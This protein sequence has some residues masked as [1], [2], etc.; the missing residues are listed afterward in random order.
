MADADRHYMCL[1]FISTTCLLT[2]VSAAEVGAPKVQVITKDALG[3]EARYDKSGTLIIL[4]QTPTTLRLFGTNFT[5]ST[6]IAFTAKNASLGTECSNLGITEEIVS[7]TEYDSTSTARFTVKLRELAKGQKYFYLC[8]KDSSGTDDW[9]HQGD[10]PWVRI[11]TERPLEE[12]T[13][14]PLWLQII[15]IG[16]LLC[17]SG[18]FSG[19]N[20]GLMS[21]DKTELKII[22][23][24]GSSS[25]KKYAK[26]ISPVRQRGNFLLCTLLLG[27]VLVNNTLTILLDDLTNGL[28]AIIGSTMAI[29][30]FGEIVPQAICSRHGL[31]VGAKT[32]WITRLFMV[33]TFVLS[34]PISL[35][36]DKILGEEIGQVYNREKLQELIRV[37]RDLND[38]EN[39]EMNIISG[40]LELSKKTVKDVMTKIEDVFMME[41]DAMLDFEA[42][43]NIMKSGFTRIPVYQGDRTNIVALLNMKD[44]AFVDP[45]DKIP[46]KTVCRFYNRRLEWVFEDQKLGSMLQDFRQGRSHMAI[47]QRVNNEGEGDP[48]YE[49][50]GLVTLEDVIEEII[51]S[52][53]LDE[54]DVISDNRRKV[55]RMLEKQDFSMFNRQDEHHLVRLSPQLALAAFQFLSTAVEPFKPDLIAERVL[56]KL[57]EQNIVV[58]LRLK[59]ADAVTN[60]LYREGVACDYF[61]L[62]LEGHVEVS[63]GREHLVFDGGPFTFYGLRALLSIKETV[64]TS[65]SA[66]V[67]HT[68]F[69]PFI[70]DY[71]LK[72]VC[73]LQFL[74]ITRAHYIAARRATI[75][76]QSKHHNTVPEEAFAKELKKL[77]SE[78][79]NNEKG[80]SHEKKR[81]ESI[82][83]QKSTSSA[84][85][86]IMSDGQPA[87]E[88]GPAVVSL[89]DRRG[90][91][92]SPSKLSQKSLASLKDAICNTTDALVPPIPDA[93]TEI[94]E[95]T[96][97]ATTEQTSLIEAPKAVPEDIGFMG[98][99]NEE[100]DN[101]QPADEKTLLVG[102]KGSKEDCSADDGKL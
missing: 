34:F 39:D 32:I 90:S 75:L 8:V 6:T 36:L 80:K 102:D 1:L 30:I 84:G 96:G 31:A 2:L 100:S 79:D 24:C 56:R 51:Q 42:V 76:G 22:E 10:W 83:S 33:L 95:K 72:A 70:P 28:F 85:P 38:L 37:T 41:H 68:K 73:D 4:S 43:S 66:D 9:V 52:E 97:E 89:E 74:K 15:I 98:L 88:V 63:V 45:D 91:I 87:V 20:L 77:K 50:V 26:L 64:F 59:E 47:V 62:I 13:L 48:F 17:L 29:V 11:K 25:E 16:I 65:K 78:S 60:Y 14:M 93:F 92:G 5:N 67:A 86:V 99:A 21:L 44:L 19:L 18:L 23:N 101:S 7:L 57:F 40:A 81:T 27:N 53:I 3:T 12:T 71:S 49:T 54:T 69:E 61:V 58:N 35:I 46:L 82:A 55:P 94:N